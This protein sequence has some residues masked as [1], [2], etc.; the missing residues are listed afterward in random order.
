MLH[1]Q[2][3]VMFVKP[4]L[5]LEKLVL[6]IGMI[7][8]KIQEMRF[9]SLSPT[10]VSVPI[11]PKSNQ[12]VLLLLLRNSRSKIPKACSSN[13]PCFNF[14]SRMILLFLLSVFTVKIRLEAVTGSRSLRSLL[15]LNT[16]F[17]PLKRNN[18][19]QNNLKR[20]NHN[21]NKNVFSFC[22]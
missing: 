3:F 21:K 1:Y 11:H 19:T 12:L 4:L 8:D 20:T 2:I 15:V 9:T 22:S 16:S 6:I 5:L 13:S 17:N 7:L 10:F 14:L 18:L